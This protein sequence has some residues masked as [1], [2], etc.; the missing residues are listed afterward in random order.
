MSNM[1]VEK[2]LNQFR[3]KEDDIIT[4][5]SMGDNF[6]GKFTLDAKQNKKFNKLYA[7][8]IND[9]HTFSIG[10]KPKE[11]G[12]ILVDI[13]LESNNN[14][15]RL[16]NNNM[17]LEII[18]TYREMAKK[19]LNLQ[20]NEQQASLFEKPKPTIKKNNV[21]KDGFHLIF[22]NIICN[23]KLRYIIRDDVVKKLTGSSTFNNY[24]VDK[25]IDKAV[26]N[27]NCWLMI[28]SKKP[29]GQLYELTKLFNINNDLLDYTQISSDKYEFVK[30]YSLQYKTNSKEYACMLN[31]GVNIDKEFLRFDRK[32]TNNKKELVNNNNNNKASI[33]LEYLYDYDDYDIWSKV[34]MILKN[35]LNNDDGLTLYLEWSQQSNKF[36]LNECIKFYNNYK[37]DGSLKFGTLIMLAKDCNDENSYNQMMKKLNE[38]NNNSEIIGVFNDKEAAIKVYSLYKHWVCCK[39]TLYVFDDKTGLWSDSET[40]MFN[41]ISRFDEH[42]FLLSV[43]HKNE[44]V[45]T[46]KGYGN[47]T[48]LQR[49]MIPQ[50]K[51]ICVNDNWL[52]AT[53]L[54]SMNK[55][56]FTNGYYEMNTGIFYDKFDPEIVF[57]NRIDRQYK[58][59]DNEPYIN[60]VKQRFFYNQLG[61]EIGN[62]LMLNLARSLAG[63]RMKK[64]FFNLG[65]TNAGKSTVVNACI[66][67]FGDYIGNF[68]GENL[69]IKNTSG[70][71]AQLLRWAYLLRYKRII[72]SN[73]MKT[74]C[75]LSCNMMKK[76]SSGGDELTGRFH[77]G[78]ET[79]FVPHYNVYCNA[80]DLPEIKPKYDEA[81]DERL[82]IISYNK[83]Y[84]DEPSNEYELKKDNNINIEM[85]NDDFIQAFQNII[86]TIYLDFYKDGSKE[87]IPESVKNCKTEWVGEDSFNNSI[88]KFLEN[89]EI[90]NNDNDFI[91]SNEIDF[92]IKENNLTLSIK[93][94]TMDLKKY[95]N[96]KKYNNVESKQIKIKNKAIRGWSGIKKIDDDDD[97]EL[98][99]LDI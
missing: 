12:P 56:L 62:Y 72:F 63:N 41:I 52:T 37:K 46:K 88:N 21:I 86:F 10:E 26:V 51:S 60:S 59:Y 85:K 23:Y 80:N 44:I 20:P 38:L 92:F 61:E 82:N 98:D 45:K 84:V 96:I 1:E 75:T 32:P 95:C 49:Q 66:N 39:E 71:E 81:I 57:F 94:F 36:D 76:V 29:D 65:A 42:L 31:N 93:K 87:F 74:E 64:I 54:T 43:N 2:Y 73:E 89:F 34:G 99:P 35:E 6:K 7:K 25:V 18:D 27:T 28:N 53:N 55:L 78:N 4:H 13:D 19:Y 97:D 90:T 3:A 17:I 91:K 83:K 47:T 22:P 50:I 69:C 48:T 14:T 15:N 67:T 11:Y 40:T 33:I 5:I 79:S 16:Y 70:D 9:G 77:I 24:D 8:A 68:N 58:Y 30:Y